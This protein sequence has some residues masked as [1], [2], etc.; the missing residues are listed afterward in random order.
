MTVCS[1]STNNG[2]VNVM[3]TAVGHRPTSRPD[4]V[5][6]PGLAGHGRPSPATAVRYRL[7]PEQRPTA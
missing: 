7:T 1:V 2:R 6:A 3:I 4:N 5:T